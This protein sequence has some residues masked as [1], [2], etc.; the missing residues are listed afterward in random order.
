[1]IKNGALDLNVVRDPAK[2]EVKCQRRDGVRLRGCGGG[3]GIFD[4]ALSGNDSG[5]VV[6][7]TR[8]PQ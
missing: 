4:V 1:M 3:S 5:Q 8:V 6:I 7:L 2:V